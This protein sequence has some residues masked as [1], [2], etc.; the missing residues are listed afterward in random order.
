MWTES[1]MSSAVQQL[2]PLI[3]K[4]DFAGLGTTIQQLGLDLVLSNELINYC[5]LNSESVMVIFLTT[6]AAHNGPTVEAADRRQP[7]WSGIKQHTAQPLGDGV[8]GVSDSS[9]NIWKVDQ[10]IG[11]KQN[12]VGDRPLLSICIPTF[13]RADILRKTLEHLYQVCDATVEIVVADN[14]SPD[15]TQEVID[16]YKAKFRYFRSIR[17]ERNLG[18]SKNTS[19]VVSI[20]R[21]KYVY[22]LC[23][24][25]EILYEG[26]LRAIRLME[27]EPTVVAVYGGYQEWNRESNAV[28]ATLRSVETRLDFARGEKFAIFTR[29][30]LLWLPVCRADI[31]Q[32]WFS[33]DDDSFGMWPLVGSLIEHGDVAVIPDLF[34]KHAHTEPRMEFELTESWY[35]DSHRAQYEVFT[36]RIGA[37]NPQEL[38]TF[39]NSRVGPAYMQGTRFAMMKGQILKARHFIL[40]ARAYGFVDEATVL[41]WERE[42]MINMI[43]EKLLG[44]ISLLPDVREVLFEST[45]SLSA[46]KAQFASIARNFRVDSF[47]M[48][49][50]QTSILEP[51]KFFITYE[52]IDNKQDEKI[53]P[54]LDRANFQAA[55]DLMESCR[56]T[57]QEL[58]L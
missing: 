5:R 28:L 38:A 25:D 56:L 26:I 36:G 35:H 6:L 51:G 24:D 48:T 50:L 58:Q 18:A 41:Q 23:D 12:L 19:S 11:D 1:Q 17:H 31:Y 52:Y 14:N 9:K 27:E 45:P 8:E 46:F 16:D 2:Q 42:H 44:R 21:G 47:Q 37:A 49:E 3:A 15:H 20:S 4:E 29:F 13:N 53:F 33:Y 54:S 57:D 30:G 43:S 7:D 32:R 22:T 10:S 39:I 34:Y 40:R 55:L